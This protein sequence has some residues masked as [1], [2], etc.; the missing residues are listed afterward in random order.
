MNKVYCYCCYCYFPQ[1]ISRAGCSRNGK[2][3]GMVQTV[4]PEKRRPRLRSPKGKATTDARDWCARD[5]WYRPV[6]LRRMV[7]TCVRETDGTDLC[8]WDG[9]YRPVSVRRMVQT[10]VRETNG[11]DL[12]PWD[13]WCRPVSLRRKART[14]GR[15]CPRDWDFR[16]GRPRRACLSLKTYTDGAD[17]C[18]SCINCDVVQWPSGPADRKIGTSIFQCNFGA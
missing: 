5:V 13:G 2:P 10:C 11:T 18:T 6:S 14:G 1:Q 17:G 12:C 15:G 8:P 7:Q 4:F 9:M 16:D 3:K